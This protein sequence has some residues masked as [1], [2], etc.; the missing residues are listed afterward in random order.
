MIQRYDKQQARRLRMAL[1]AD[2]VYCIVSDALKKMYPE[3]TPLNNVEIWMAAHGLTCDLIQSPA[4]EEIFED[5]LAELREEIPCQARNEDESPH[6]ALDAAS[7]GKKGIP[8]HLIPGLTRKRNEEIWKRNE[9]TTLFLILMVS[10]CQI[11]AL[12]KQI[13]NA[14]A[15]LMRLM[16]VCRKNE[17]YFSVLEQFDGKEIRMRLVDRKVDLLT[18]EMKEV[19]DNKEAQRQML[20]D[21]AQ[22]ALKF[23]PQD[24]E[25]NLLALN[26]YNLKNGH[27]CDDLILGMYEQLEKKHAPQKAIE[28]IM[29]NKNIAQNGGLQMNGEM[30][31]D[32]LGFLE[33][34]KKLNLLGDGK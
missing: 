8:C 2:D 19:G 15:L 28:M 18:Y 23:R 14:D 33:S 27:I 7:P 10:M 29:G 16:G 5:L 11:S 12:R 9:G 25:S 21:F 31:Q 1:V 26:Y 32:V 3:K 4:P 34:F 13:K 24:I 20:D 22:A 17:M 6:A 30:P